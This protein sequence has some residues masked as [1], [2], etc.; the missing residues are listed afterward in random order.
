[1]AVKARALNGALIAWR[2][3]GR[4]S[5]LF[6]TAAIR[7]YVIWGRERAVGDQSAWTRQ[8]RAYSARPTGPGGDPAVA[9][10]ARHEPEKTL[11]HEV[12]RAR[13]VPFLAG[14]RAAGAPVARFVEREIRA[15]LE[16]GLLAHGFFLVHCDACGHDRL[17]AFS[18][19]GRE[20]CPSCGGRRM[21]DTAAPLVARVL[22]EVPIRQWVLTL[23]Y[24]LRHRCAWNARLASEV[25]RNFRRAVFADQRLRARKLFGIR[26]GPLEDRDG[27]RSGRALAT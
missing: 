16:R 27:F 20:F 26:K 6:R 10:Y 25:L 24:P 21:A 17:V 15:Y 2:R 5:C 11:L 18:C 8:S 3:I 1:M 4:I 23:P 22:P 12:I 7:N 14:A 9:D 13:L 19:K